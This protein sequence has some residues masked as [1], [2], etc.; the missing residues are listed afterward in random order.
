MMRTTDRGI[1]QAIMRCD[2]IYEIVETIYLL[3][4]FPL[5]DNSLKQQTHQ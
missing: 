5:T 3:A 4:G 1:Y 2:T